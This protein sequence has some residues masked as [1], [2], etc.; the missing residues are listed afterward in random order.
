MKIHVIGE[1]F[2]VTEAMNAQIEEKVKK[3]V[4]HMKLPSDFTVFL[5]KIGSYEFE[6]KFQTHSRGEDFVGE[7][8]DKDFY[9]ALNLAKK[10]ILRQLDDHHAKKVNARRHA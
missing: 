4:A 3:I 8:K 10:S 2:S 5:K 9:V 7:G 1:D 6:V